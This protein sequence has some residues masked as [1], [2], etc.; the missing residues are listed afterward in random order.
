MTRS[1]ASAKKAGTSMETASAGYLATAL[2]APEIER[3]RLNGR[4]DRGDLTGVKTIRGAAVVVEVKDYN[5]KVMVKPWLDEAETERGNADAA[6]A[7][8]VFKRARIP[9]S[10]PGEQG[11]LMTLATLAAL[12]EGGP[13]DRPVVVVDPMTEVAA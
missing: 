11:V 4:Y 7:V 5:G 2:K 9:Y 13:D 3:R 6:L 1:R 10:N 8:V 12:L